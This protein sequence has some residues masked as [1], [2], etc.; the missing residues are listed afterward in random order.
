[1]E[2]EEERRVCVS[3]VGCGN[4]AAMTLTKDKRNTQK[5]ADTIDIEH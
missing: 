5:S 4:K 3:G 1:M 2:R